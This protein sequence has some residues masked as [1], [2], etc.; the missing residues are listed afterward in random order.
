[1][2]TNETYNEFQTLKSSVLQRS[3][4]ICRRGCCI[5]GIIEQMKL[6]LP[7]KTLDKPAQHIQVIQLMET[8]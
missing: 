8:A 1:M 5:L 6:S 7:S 3:G 2:A 4:D